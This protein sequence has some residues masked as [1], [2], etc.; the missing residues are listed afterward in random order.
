MPLAVVPVAFTRRT[1]MGR[2]EKS[3]T[4]MLRVS[5]VT[6]TTLRVPPVST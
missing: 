3:A 2:T 4:A 5:P 6:V 1:P